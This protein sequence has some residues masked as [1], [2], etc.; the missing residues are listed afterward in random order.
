MP[1]VG[2]SAKTSARSLGR[3]KAAAGAVALGMVALGVGWAGETS[4]AYADVTTA[5][6]AIGALTPPVGSLTVAPT[7]ATV[8]TSTNFEISFVATVGLATSATITVRDSTSGNSVVVTTSKVQVSD[9]AG[10]CLEPAPASVTSS[11]GGLTV[12]LGTG[13]SVSGGDNVTLGLVATA[14][15]SSGSLTFDVTTSGNAT[16]AESNPVTVSTAPPA[17]AAASARGGREHHL[18]DCRRAGDGT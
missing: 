12:T 13:C 6:Y 5:G 17:V 2:P 16:P 3:A 7:I 8:G 1:A 18:L 14:P 15:S 4:P 11:G 10:T 9:S